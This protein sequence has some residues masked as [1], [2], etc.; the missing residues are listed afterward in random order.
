MLDKL[1]LHEPGAIHR[2]HYPTHR[3]VVHSDPTREPVQAVTI[4]RRR[5]VIDQL[6]WP[7]IKQTSTRR[8]LRSKPTCNTIISLPEQDQPRPRRTVSQGRPSIGQ[9]SRAAIIRAPLTYAVR[10]GGPTSF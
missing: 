4:R 9:P 3:L 2:L 1:A 10:S 8:R 5:E 6:A 7:E